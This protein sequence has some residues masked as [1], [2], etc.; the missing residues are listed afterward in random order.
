MFL[1]AL[2]Y[3]RW[4][5][6]LAALA[7]NIRELVIARA[8][9]GFGAAFLVPGSLSIISASSAKSKRGGPSALGPASPPSPRLLGPVLGGWLIE[10]ASWRWVFF[11]NVPVAVAVFVLSSGGSLKAKS[12]RGRHRLDRAR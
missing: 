12:P 10:H 7:T 11:I 5:R 8:V 1:R 4:L 3:L 9:Q 6:R 2:R